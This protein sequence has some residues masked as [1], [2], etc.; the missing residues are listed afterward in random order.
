MQTGYKKNFRQ[1]FI[2]SPACKIQLAPNLANPLTKSNFP[3]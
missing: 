2:Y 1:P 3:P